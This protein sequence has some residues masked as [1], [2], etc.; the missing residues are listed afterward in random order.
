MKDRA[1]G[2]SGTTAP[3]NGTS[4]PALEL[5]PAA[6]MF[7]R[8]VEQ[9]EL[10]E[11]L[12]DGSARL[13]TLT[14]RG[15]VGKTRLAVEVVRAIGD[16]PG[17]R[18]VAVALAGVAGAEMVIGEI[19]TAIGVAHVP[20]IDVTDAVAA[21][22]RDDDVLLMLDNFE[23]VLPAAPALGDLLDRCPNTR[24]LV[25]S[26]AP[27][28]LRLEHVCRLEPLPVPELGESNAELLIQS[29][30]VAVYCERAAAV[31]TRFELHDGNA[32]AVAELC[33][34][35]EGLPLAIELAAARA[36]TLPAAEILRRLETAGLDVLRRRLD[37][38]P[39]R[40]HDLR[41]A[42]EWTYRLA[43]PS[44]QRMLRRLSA[45]SG[46]FS[47]D[48]VE[49]L[50][51]PILSADAIDQLAALVD[52]HLVDPI[53][54]SDPARFHMP[55]SIR[56]FGRDELERTG[57]LESERGAHLA[58]RAREAHDAAKGVESADEATSLNTLR[59]DHDDLVAALE[60]ALGLERA[61]DAIDLAS[62]LLPLWSLRGYYAAQ[63]QLVDRT[64][65]LGAA[66]GAASIA[67]ATVLLWSGRLGLQQGATVDREILLS[68]MQRGE[69]LARELNHTPTILRALAYRMLAVPYTGNVA[70]A[71][72]ASDEGLELAERAEEQRWLGQIEAW[73][74]MLATLMADDERAVMLGR[75]A[76]T[77]ARRNG[78]QRT[79]VIATMMLMPLR[80]KYPEIAPDVPPTAEA[81]RCRA[82]D[83]PQTVRGAAARD[84]GRR[85]S[86]RPR[87]PGRAGLGGRGTRSGA[88]DAGL[89]AWS[90]THS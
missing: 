16:R 53:R 47:L 84:D 57:E 42:I 51:S 46:T 69:T 81:L 76:V 11:T 67:Y 6:P 14:G 4:L 88:F 52:L 23:H 44:E 8:S 37:D 5:Q 3:R 85:R 62:G 73:S 33:R 66:A 87:R 82:S 64:L 2:P 58:M 77:R 75:S 59:A 39:E 45:V 7:G 89:A 10:L 61:D 71:K 26:Q 38:A 24:I 32:G 30:S 27:L 78:D 90:A 17:P 36:A 49:A 28:R 18:V 56:A 65:R 41:R 25:T 19:A 74:G 21:R 35:L 80:R 29:P 68:R 40:H 79:L 31:E 63:E 12:R 60:T 1:P 43:A 9:A 15:G 22:I 48:T 83:R 20:S 50:S 55:S 86:S 70:D 72:D 34:Q 13:I 54:G